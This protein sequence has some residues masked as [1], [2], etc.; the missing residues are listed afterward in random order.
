MSAN[1][2]YN[3]NSREDE[4]HFD[5]PGIAIL[6]EKEW[7]YLQRYYDMSPRELQVAKLVCNGF[8]NGDIADKLNVKP[9]TVKTHMRSIFGKTRTRNR[10]S[11]LLK[12]VEKV[13]YIHNTNGTV[14]VPAPQGNRENL[15]INRMPQ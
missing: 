4:N 11:M 10:I 13:Q 7:S 9:G 15:G 6:N 2:Q 1:E 5:A 12:Y 14:N 8:T 3:F